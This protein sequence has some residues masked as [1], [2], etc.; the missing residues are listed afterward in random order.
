LTIR[1]ALRG[2]GS[3]STLPAISNRSDFIKTLIDA[4]AREKL[5]VLQWHLTDDQGWR[6]EIK[7]FPRL[8]EVGAWRVPAVKRAARHRSR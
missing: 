2:G 1:R 5:N 3:C 8:T 4:M 7:K 6:L